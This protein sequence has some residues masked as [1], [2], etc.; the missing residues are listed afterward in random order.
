MTTE[1]A[2]DIS[3]ATP[4]ALDAPTP[5]LAEPARGIRLSWG[6]VIGGLLVAIAVW[7]ALSVLGLAVNLTA[8]DPQNPAALQGIGMAAGLWSL[9]VW[10]VAL[11]AGGVVAGHAA[12]IRRRRGALQDRALVAG[13]DASMFVVADAVRAV[14]LRR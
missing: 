4:P 12:G 9:V 3:T 6:G 7:L 2:A 14:A 1:T 11:F 5:R 8:L 13:D 10:I